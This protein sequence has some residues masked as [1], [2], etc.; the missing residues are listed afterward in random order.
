M[1]YNS[2]KS[3]FS[4]DAYF[5]FTRG[6]IELVFQVVNEH[7][8]PQILQNAVHRVLS[9]RAL[10]IPLSGSR[11]STLAKASRSLA[12]RSSDDDGRAEEWSW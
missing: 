2:T 12:F 8:P 4:T 9:L 5:H 11:L 6:G 1:K 7:L 3:R 10:A